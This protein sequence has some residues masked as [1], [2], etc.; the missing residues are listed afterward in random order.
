MYTPIPFLKLIASAGFPSPA[1]DFLDPN[2]NLNKFLITNPP[3]TFCVKV[4]GDSMIGARIYSGDV[5]IVDR[6]LSPKNNNIV[7]ATLNGN[8]IVKKIIITHSKIH[9]MSDDGERSEKIY[10]NDQTEFNI[11]GVVTSVINKLIE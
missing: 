7:L 8:F 9:L 5:L 1:E 4:K 3:A 2:L 10:I 11:W 6:S